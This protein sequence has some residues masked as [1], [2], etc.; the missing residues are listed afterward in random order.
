MGDALVGKRWVEEFH[1][2]NQ[3]GAGRFRVVP[4]HLWPDRLGELAEEEVVQVC[5]CV[6]CGGAVVCVGIDI[7]RV[8]NGGGLDL[9]REKGVIW[10]FLRRWAPCRGPEELQK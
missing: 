9:E 7:R 8:R 4:A 5:V 6:E 1:F 10:R 3:G 2:E